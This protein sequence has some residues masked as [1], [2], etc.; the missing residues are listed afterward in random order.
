MRRCPACRG[1]VWRPFFNSRTGRLMTGDQRVGDG[2]LAKIICATCGVVAN[3][4]PFDQR[5]IEFLYGEAYELNTLGREEHV[6][7]TPAGPVAR[8]QA[9]CDWIAP[10]VAT[11]TR[12]L[13]EIGC[14]EGNLLSRLH[15]RFPA[16]EC[17]GI[18]GSRRAAELGAAK[19]LA[20]RQQLLGQEALPDADVFL[21]VNVIEHLED[22]P[23]VISQLRAALRPSGRII[24]CLPIQDYG[25]YDMFFAEHVWHFTAD[26]FRAVAANA[27]LQ[28]VASET[29][30]PIH[31]GIGLFVCTADEAIPAAEAPQDQSALQFQHLQY[32]EQAFRRVDEWCRTQARARLAVFGAGEVFTLFQAFTALGECNIVACIDDTKPAGATKHGVPVYPTDWL[33]THH[34]DTVVLAVNRK[35]HDLIRDKVRPYGAVVYPLV[36]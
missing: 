19:G 15:S 17:Y 33:V 24:F 5:A 6:Y 20:I 32:W 16:V 31:H 12:R 2:D 35:Y 11:S 23:G 25:G 21:L 1:G 30:H 7:F 29:T 9:F 18:D 28:I 27:G 13:V 4:D 3:R 8:S 36:T 26:H 14:G 22:I 10:Y 34:V